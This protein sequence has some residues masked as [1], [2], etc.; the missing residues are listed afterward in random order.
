MTT[1]LKIG[2]RAQSESA[3]PLIAAALRSSDEQYVLV[4]GGGDGVSELQRRLGFEPRFIAGRRVTSAG[5]LEVVRMVLSA[6]A[7]KRIV[8]ALQ[9]CE[10]RAVGISGEDGGLLSAA[11]P[12]GSPLGH[13]GE[14]VQVDTSLLND[15][16]AN[17]WLPVISPLAVDRAHPTNGLNVN[18][19]DAAAA[20]AVALRARELALIADVEGVLHDGA[21]I[22]SL[23]PDEVSA[24]V[25]SGAVTG[26]MIAK[27][28]AACRALT[29][30]VARVRITSPDGL[31]RH[32]AGTVLH[33]SSASV[34]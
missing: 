15:L 25:A 34:P 28:D 26:G 32:D 7:N 27:L 14:A 19:D 9:A 20:I 29:F 6:S 18:G 12:A 30:G 24:L 11:A 22:P 16:L 10:I 5:E 2:G 3:W 8:R 33:P 23:A 13:V 4:H 31:R 17:G 21:V 1:I